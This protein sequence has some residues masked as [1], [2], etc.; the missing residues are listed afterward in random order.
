MAA[1]FQ[2]AVDTVEGRMSS[3]SKNTVLLTEEDHQ[4][5]NVL[6]IAFQLELHPIGPV[7]RPLFSQIVLSAWNMERANRLEAIL[8][9]SRGIDPLVDG[10][11]A[12]ALKRMG[13][14][15][16]GFSPAEMRDR[17][18]KTTHFVT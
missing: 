3:S 11:N 6:S 7:E 18:H 16:E 15:S 9:A 8:A 14:V 13:L 10:A 12:K 4:A 1:Q 5:F 17:P 2:I